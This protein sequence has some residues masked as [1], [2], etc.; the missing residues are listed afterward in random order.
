MKAQLIQIIARLSPSKFNRVIHALES[1]AMSKPKRAQLITI[2]VKQ[3]GTLLLQLF[4]VVVVVVIIVFNIVIIVIAAVI[5]VS[6]ILL[7][8]FIY[9]SPVCP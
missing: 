1:Q 6:I 5:T 9:F 8:A 3:R 4:V 7:I 2:L